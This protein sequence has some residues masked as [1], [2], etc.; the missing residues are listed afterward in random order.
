MDIVGAHLGW[1]MLEKVEPANWADLF[2]VYFNE[3]V[4]SLYIEAKCKP[5]KKYK[6]ACEK[7]TTKPVKSPME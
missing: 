3:P 7:R 6:R 5:V 2:S 1:K 4:V